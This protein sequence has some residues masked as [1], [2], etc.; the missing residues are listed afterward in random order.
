MSNFHFLHW[1]FNARLVP[2]E[3]AVQGVKSGPVAEGND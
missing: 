2:A 1:L 3:N